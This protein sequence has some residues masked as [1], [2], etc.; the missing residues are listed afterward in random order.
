MGIAVSNPTGRHEEV[1]ASLVINGSKT[2][3][4]IVK[5][6]G[7]NTHVIYVNLEPEDTI[8]FMSE[9]TTERFGRAVISLLL[10]IY[11]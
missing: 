8:N 9:T 3:I 11:L 4:K 7:K 1:V 10:E 6:P 2:N 5:P